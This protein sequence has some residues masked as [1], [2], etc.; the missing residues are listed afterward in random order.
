MKNTKHSPHFSHVL[1]KKSDF[2]HQVNPISIFASS[3]TSRN[4]R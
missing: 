4:R 2:L 3:A 1:I